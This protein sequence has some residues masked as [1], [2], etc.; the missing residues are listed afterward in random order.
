MMERLLLS[1]I[2]L[3][4]G[5]VVI[6]ALRYVHMHRVRQAALLALA[7]GCGAGGLSHPLLLGN[8]RRR[9]Q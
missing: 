7:E 8:R 2:I 4:L 5:L 9:W 3:L 6:L 1:P